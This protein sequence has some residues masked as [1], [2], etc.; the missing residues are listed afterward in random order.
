MNL[1]LRDDIVARIID[2]LDARVRELENDNHN[3]KIVIDAAEHALAAKERMIM[4][5][6]NKNALLEQE[7][8]KANAKPKNK[9]CG[10][11]PCELDYDSSIHAWICPHC[12]GLIHLGG[13]RE[14]SES[15]DERKAFEERIEGDNSASS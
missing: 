8:E 1:D 10:N 7:K 4:A 5:I 9:I 6:K 2:T 14:R 12:R 11:K 13:E 3:Q 15:G